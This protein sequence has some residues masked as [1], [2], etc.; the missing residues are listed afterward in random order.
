MKRF[1]MP[2]DLL[3]GYAPIDDDHRHLV[4]LFNDMV[5]LPESASAG[6]FAARFEAFAGAFESHCTAE[7]EMLRGFDFPDTEAHAEHHA[8][9]IAQARKFGDAAKMRKYTG[10]MKEQF[11]RTAIWIFLEDAIGEDPK[12]KSFLMQKGLI[13]AHHD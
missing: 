5:S 2:G 6:Q 4:A 1:E 7:M 13:E 3:L 12:V 9:L 8:D 10:K 11:L